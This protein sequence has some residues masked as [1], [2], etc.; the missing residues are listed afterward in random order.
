[1]DLE[2]NRPERSNP[3]SA[4]WRMNLEKFLYFFELQFP[5][6]Y[7]EDYDHIFLLGLW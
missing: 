2:P 6:L 3:G 1:M 7:D 4:L 5:N